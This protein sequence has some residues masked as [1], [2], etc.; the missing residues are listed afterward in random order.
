[1]RD[2]RKIKYN[3]VIGILGQLIMM[4]LGIIVPKVVMTSYGSEVN[5][6]ISSVTN[7]YACIAIVEAGVTA[8]SCQA[9][10]KP[11]SE[12]NRNDINAILAATHKYFHK[13]GLIYLGGIIAF[14][15]IY[16][17][18]IHSEIPYHVVVAV[19]LLNGIGNVI[20]YFF[21]GKYLILLKADGKN[22]VRTV[23]ETF[24]NA[25]K[26]ISKIVL[27]SMGFDVIL[28]Q[29]V[30]MLI[31][32]AQ[33]IYITYY[34]KKNYSWLD[35]HVAPNVT[36]FSQNKHVLVH[37]INY[38]ITFNVDTFLLTMFTTLKLVSVYSL[39]NQLFSTISRAL[40]IVRDALEF[41][42]AYAY[43]ESREKFLRIF[44]AYE[45][46]YITLAFCLFSIMQYFILPFITLYT[47]G[48][49]D[50]SYV[51][52]IY[53]LLFAFIN[54]LA[55]GRYPSDTMIHVAGHYKLTE[56]SAVMESVINVVV[57]LAL[58]WIWGISGVLIG[59]IASSM[60]RT[61]YL[62]LYVNKQIIGRSPIH[63]Y[64]CW[65]INLVVFFIVNMLNRYLV[66]N[67]DSFGKLVLMFI[68]YSLGSMCIYFGV[69]SLLEPQAFQYAWSVGKKM[70]K[71]K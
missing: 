38:L 16:P 4:I 62:I 55:A 22:Y 34:I 59:T 65:L 32:F 31:S 28:V 43:H 7:I 67:L 33:M 29:F 60:Y 6:L 40:R 52:N 41:K 49:E 50:I 61:N 45:V 27:I 37:E 14:S 18:L 17:I 70:L 64:K 5:G 44:T 3:L 19:I 63:T 9:L 66:L 13:T 39:Y 48:V 21:H 30:A 11:F 25:T 8:A 71:N 47:K 58:V 56:K 51:S 57:S 35:L 68:P 23:V 53:P 15:A 26:H 12:H 20:N 69:I 42:I 36:V 2:D 54:L 24:T 1:M 10:Y 46:Y